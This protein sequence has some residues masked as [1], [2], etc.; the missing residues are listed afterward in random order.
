MYYFILKEFPLFSDT[1][2][3]EFSENFLLVCFFNIPE[4]FKNVSNYYVTYLFYN[5]YAVLVE[6]SDIFSSTSW[7]CSC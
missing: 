2:Y 6:I 4:S 1:L 7:L 3:S 5:I